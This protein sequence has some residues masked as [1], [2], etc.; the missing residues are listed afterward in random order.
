M[1]QT[2]VGQ[3][4]QLPTAYSTAVGQASHLQQQQQQQQQQQ[5]VSNRSSAG[6]TACQHLL[7]SAGACA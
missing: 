7:V 4:D 3:Q 2:A 5:V 1:E 6:E